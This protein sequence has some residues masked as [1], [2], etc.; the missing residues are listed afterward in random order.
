MIVVPGFAEK[1]DS[2]AGH[3]PACRDI[4]IC[5]YPSESNC[6]S[7]WNSPLTVTVRGSAGSLDTTFG[8][9]GTANVATGSGLDYGYAAAQ[10]PDG[11][12]VVVGDISGTYNDFGV[13]RLTRE[14]GLD[15]TFGKGGQVVLDF[16]GDRDTARAVALQQDG[17][18][19]VAGGATLPSD[20]ERFG[21][22][23]L[24]PD[25]TLDPSFGTG[26]KLTTAFPASSA[27]RAG[28]M[29]I[30]PD[31]RILVGGQASR[32]SATTGV[33]FALA[34]YLPGGTL[35]PSFGSGG[36][37]VTPVGGS[38]SSDKIYALAL[39]GNKII[40]GG[41]DAFAVVRYSADG[42]LDSSFDASAI[43]TSGIVHSLATDG[44]GRVIVAG[45]QATISTVMRLSSN[46]TADPIFGVGG[47][48]T[49][50]LNPGLESRATGVALQL[51]GKLVVG[52]W[53]QETNST[54]ANFAL[55]RL[56][57]TGQPD[58]SFGHGG[59]TITAT[60]KGNERANAMLLQPDNRVAATRIVLAGFNDGPDF[61][62]TRYW[63]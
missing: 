59:T 23:R 26:G 42:V 21:L 9:G 34:R 2:Q 54:N 25:G 27:D 8:K 5:V 19:V 40:A 31:N 4:P 1:Y 13:I 38:S 56:T 48:I 6:L 24:N 36:Q 18:I 28:A 7:A 63:P 33:D 32:N 47:K 44:Q 52:G 39:Q 22:L 43:A 46:G 50:N 16:A 37:V 57:P 60:T 10:Q 14:G 62:L 61:S 53:V 17:K 58:A 3:I 29:L 45:E 55:T 49:L 15:S 51:D 20:S 12:L 30:L 11:K 41:G 35:D